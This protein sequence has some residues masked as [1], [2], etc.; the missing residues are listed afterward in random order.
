VAG[1][2]DKNPDWSEMFGDSEEVFK[3]FEELTKLQMEG[4]DVYMQAFSNLKHFDF[5]RDFENWFMP[6]HPDHEA[7]DDIFRDEILGPGTNELAEA[8]YKTPFICN[9]DKYSL[10]LNLKYREKNHA[11]CIHYYTVLQL[12]SLITSDPG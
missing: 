1:K 10:L 7:V 11:Y 12:W 3:S 5:F 4:A 2:H 6:F 8:L 9:S